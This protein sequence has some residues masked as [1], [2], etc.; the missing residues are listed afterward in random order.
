[1]DL[2]S[3]VH[4]YGYAAVFA[5]SCLEGE[6]LVALAGLAA[7]RGYLALPWVMA[8][9]AVGS[10]IGDQAGFW[11]GRRWGDRVVARFPRLAGPVARALGALERY[12][13]VTVPM[14]RFMYG[15]RLAG[16]VAFGM[17]RIGPLRFMVLNLAGAVLWAVV[18]AGIGY[19]FGE[20]LTWILGDLGRIEQWAFVALVLISVIAWLVFRRR[21]GDRRPAALQ[22][23]S[24]LE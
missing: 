24:R 13:L 4:S 18:I 6:T 21:A 8:I 10:F 14:I 2:A 19:G 15:M 3:L 20:A 1:M 22:Q 11:I 23:R 12:S 17:S 9:A 16:G 5:G 7:H